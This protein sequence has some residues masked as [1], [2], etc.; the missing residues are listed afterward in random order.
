MKVFFTALATVIDR[1][2]WMIG[3]MTILTY[4][5]NHWPTAY[6]VLVSILLVGFG[7]WYFWKFF[8]QP[9]RAGLRGQ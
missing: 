2:I 7:I 5:L 1:I 4:A 8:I 9:F 6:R 3:V